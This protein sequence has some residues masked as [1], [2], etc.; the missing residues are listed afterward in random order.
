[1][2]KQFVLGLTLLFVSGAALL[3]QATGTTSG[4]TS[5]SSTDTMSSSSSKKG[6]GST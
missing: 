3:A 6:T 5:G 4:S 2:R 1:M